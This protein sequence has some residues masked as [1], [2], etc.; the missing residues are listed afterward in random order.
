MIVD[1]QSAFISKFKINGSFIEFN[2]ECDK[3][4]YQLLGS[5]TIYEKNE[6]KFTL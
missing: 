2:D 3:K 5:K 6:N 1:L 4:Y